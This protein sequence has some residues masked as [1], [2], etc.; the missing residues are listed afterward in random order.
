MQSFKM[1]T[2]SNLMLLKNKTIERLFLIVFPPYGEESFSQIDIRIGL[3]LS[4]SSDKLI[5]VGADL[6]NL[7]SPKISIEKLPKIYFEGNQFDSRIHKWMKT[8]LNEDFALEYYEVTKL[9][10]FKNIVKNQ[11]KEIYYISIDNSNDP[12]GL[13][14]VFDE[15]NILSFP[16]SD[17]NS[18]E[19]KYFNCQ[20]KILNYNSI[21]D[22]VYTK[23]LE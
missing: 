18:I 8:E 17:G 4:E 16:N 13:K 23:L 6:N 14:F 12:F 3:V 11:I 10:Y 20:N 1:M 22:I 19:T 2:N 7:W 15:D 21:G 9:D 5:I